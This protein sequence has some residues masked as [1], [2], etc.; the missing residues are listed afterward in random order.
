MPSVDGRPSAHEPD[1]QI[2]ELLRQLADADAHTR[3]LA[4]MELADLADLTILPELIA[5]LRDSDA[6]VRR[7]AVGCARRRTGSA[8]G[9]AS[10]ARE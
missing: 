2:G 10:P 6:V 4:M 1:S 3:Q 5:A 9:R 8:S 7:I